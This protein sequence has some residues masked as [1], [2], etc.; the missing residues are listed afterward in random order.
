MGEQLTE[1]QE[2]Q[3]R[4]EMERNRLSDSSEEETE[5][6]KKPSKR[7]GQEEKQREKQSNEPTSAKVI[8]AYHP[9]LNLLGSG[10]SYYNQP[11]HHVGY[12]YQGGVFTGSLAACNLNFNKRSPESEEAKPKLQGVLGS[13]G[14]GISGG[15]GGS[16]ASKESFKFESPAPPP[17]QPRQNPQ[18]PKD[19]SIGKQ[20]SSPA[21]Q[22]QKSFSWKSTNSFEHFEQIM[23][24]QT[25]DGY[26]ELNEMTINL[27]DVSYDRISQTAQQFK[28]SLQIVVTI[29]VLDIINTYVSKKPLS[30]AHREQQTKALKYLVEKK[31]NFVS[32]RQQLVRFV[33]Q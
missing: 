15:L 4:E 22:F 20:V 32:I 29:I 2:R 12:Q 30:S 27:I 5:G 25:A 23:K 14:L 19:D 31:V 16:G 9:A 7:R 3:L 26:W 24:L 11:A 10:I 1:E 18:Q 6:Q 21:L 17:A 28:L 13:G 8:Q 33:K